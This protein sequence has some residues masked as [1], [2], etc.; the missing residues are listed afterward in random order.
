MHKAKRKPNAS[1]DYPVC[2]VLILRM[3]VSNVSPPYLFFLKRQKLQIAT[4]AHAEKEGG[5]A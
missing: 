2:Y 1:E 4:F 3:T 5:I